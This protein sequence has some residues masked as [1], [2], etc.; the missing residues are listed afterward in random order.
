MGFSISSWFGLGERRL[1]ILPTTTNSP[2]CSA[3]ISFIWFLCKGRRENWYVA[4]TASEKSYKPWGFVMPQN[5]TFEFLSGDINLWLALNFIQQLARNERRTNIV[6]ERSPNCSTTGWF[7][8]NRRLEKTAPSVL[9]VNLSPNLIVYSYVTAEDQLSVTVV[10]GGKVDRWGRTVL[11]KQQVV[12]TG[13]EIESSKKYL[14]LLEYFQLY[15]IY[16]KENAKTLWKMTFYMKNLS[17]LW[18]QDVWI[19]L[20]ITGWCLAWKQARQLFTKKRSK[21]SL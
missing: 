6:R 5:W 15:H 18:N 19:N 14:S 4:K 12:C 7:M 3:S 8:N 11:S 2:E 10:K 13:A 1:S 16:E 20:R 21:L 17:S 9:R